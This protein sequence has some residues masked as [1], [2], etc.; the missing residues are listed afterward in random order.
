[1]AV[2]LD[3]VRGQVPRGLSQ[4][5]SRRVAGVA[6]NLRFGFDSVATSRNSWKWRPPP[7]AVWHDDGLEHIAKHWA[8]SHCEPLRS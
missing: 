5:H 8:T 1:M 6:A 2:V 7:K 3:S 4:E